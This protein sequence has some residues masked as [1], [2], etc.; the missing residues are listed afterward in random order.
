[1]EDKR[2]VYMVYVRAYRKDTSVDECSFVLHCIPGH[3]TVTGVNEI[4]AEILA[5]QHPG[6]EHTNFFFVNMTKMDGE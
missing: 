4:T 3:F 6:V 5:K 2:D 1:M